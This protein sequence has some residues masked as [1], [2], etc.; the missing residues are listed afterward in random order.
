[1]TINVS[2]LVLYKFKSSY[3]KQSSGNFEISL[4][5]FLCF[6]SDEM[7]SNRV[8]KQRRQPVEN[9]SDQKNS[10]RLKYSKVF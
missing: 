6:G 1:M 9:I 10:H 7:N 4:V 2:S 8:S 5:I 3:Q